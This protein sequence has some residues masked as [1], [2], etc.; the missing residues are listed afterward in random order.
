[1]VGVCPQEQKRLP[2][3][4]ITTPAFLQFTGEVKRIGL[5]VC[6]R[7]E[8]CLIVAKKQIVLDTFDSF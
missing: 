4:V 7:G 3:K 5:S 1:M 8:I 6:N 2:S